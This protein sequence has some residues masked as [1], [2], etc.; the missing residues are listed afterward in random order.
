MQLR[1]WETLLLALNAPT[2]S[3]LADV[4]YAYRMATESILPP[5]EKQGCERRSRHAR[6]PV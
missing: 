1:G 2:R 5:V 3:M 6:W 4:M